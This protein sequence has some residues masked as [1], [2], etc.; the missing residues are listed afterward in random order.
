VHDQLGGIDLDLTGGE[1]LVHHRV[2][3]V[4]DLAGDA[5]DG[6]VLEQ[7]RLPAEIRVKLHLRDA[8]AVAEIDEN[9]ATV[10]AD[11]INPAGER[12]G[13]AEVGLGELGAVMGAFHRSGTL[14]QTARPT[15]A[16]PHFGP[17]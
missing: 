11:G 15:P 1:V 9:D 16:Q 17:L 3:A 8:L 10:V 13:R 4:L 14:N 2:R 6:L 12:H 5:D 7:R